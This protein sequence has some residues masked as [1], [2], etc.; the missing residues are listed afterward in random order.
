MPHSILRGQ[1]PAALRPFSA[2]NA[3]IGQPGWEHGLEEAVALGFD[4]VEL[5]WPFEAEAPHSSEID[6][7]VRQLSHWELSLVALNLWG[8]HLDVGERGVL[9]SRSLPEEHVDAVESI[10]R[11]LTAAGKP[12]RQFNTL[13]GRSG[14]EV[15]AEQV[16]RAAD[17]ADSLSRR[18]SG[19][20]LIEPLSGMD[21]YPVTD[22]LMAA[23]V[24]QRIDA[25]RDA[26]CAAANPTAVLLDFFHLRANGLGMEEIAEQVREV[27]AHGVD[28]GHAQWADIPG[29]GAPGTGEL[30]PEECLELLREC[31]YG[32]EFVAEYL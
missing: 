17:L 29:R 8:G 27:I 6:R 14:S 13:L 24:A 5:W 22:V 25:T 16:R 28:I 15:G 21:D 12:V 1:R 9:H 4:R 26:E 30:D 11:G 2:Y 7:L 18:I 32:G 19:R 23:E 20:L 31:G 10:Y 3:S